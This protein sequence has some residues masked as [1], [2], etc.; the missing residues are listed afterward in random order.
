MPDILDEKLPISATEYVKD[1]DM[2]FAWTN[3]YILL[4]DT[5]AMG[6]YKNMILAVN[7]LAERG[8]EAESI[9][10]D[11]SG[12]LFALVKNTHLKRKNDAS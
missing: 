3:Y 8:W 10:G 2:C 9:S 11:A 7:L 5:S 4:K 1:P 12:N 6:T